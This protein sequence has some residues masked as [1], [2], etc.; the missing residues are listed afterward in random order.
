MGM[1]VYGS[2]LGSLLLRT[3]DR[4]QRIHLAMS[5]RGFDG[6]IRTI[7]SL[8]IQPADMV[9]VGGWAAFFLAARL[10]N[11]PRLLGS[12]VMEVLR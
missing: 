2:M 10:Y 9:F 4:A 7:R 11:L 5:C 1:R 6:H 3:L 12:F 8:A